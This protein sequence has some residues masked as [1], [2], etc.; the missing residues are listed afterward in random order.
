MAALAY[1]VGGT[2]ARRRSGSAAVRAGREFGA[3][4]Q[5]RDLRLVAGAMPL[6]SRSEGGVAPSRDDLG[7]SIHFLQPHQPAGR[8]ALRSRVAPGVRSLQGYAPITPL[9]QAELVEPRRIIELPPRPEDPFVVQEREIARRVAARKRARIAR[10][11]RRRAVALLSAVATVGLFVGVWLGAGALST[12]N[13]PTLQ[14]LPGSVKSAGG[15]LYTVQPG[16]TIWSVASRL[17]TAGDPRPI[18]DQ[19]EA[20]VGGTALQA[21]TNLLVP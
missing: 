10:I 3:H 5:G 14:V 13:S 9:R 17:T 11:R 1:S 6:R 12:A 4:P 20:E 16:D 19:L 7:A 8:K 21:G 15:Y 18:V 2:R